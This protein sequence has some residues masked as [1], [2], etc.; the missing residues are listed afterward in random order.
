MKIEHISIIFLMFISSCGIN[1]PE[2]K[3]WGYFPLSV[4]NEWNYKIQNNPE[5]DY[6]STWRVNSIT[7]ISGKEYF[8]IIK[9][10]NLNSYKDTSYFRIDGSKLV[11]LIIT[12][13][14]QNF[15]TTFAD[16]SVGDDSSF[17]YRFFNVT[18][19]KKDKNS[20]TL[21]YDAPQ[22]VDEENSITFEKNKGITLFY[23]D[24]WGIGE[25]LF[26]YQIETQ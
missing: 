6:V 7:K 22:M 1:D 12:N 26:D 24:A 18:L 5:S 19:K 11:E 10:N 15:E 4:G 13:N 3:A 9:E 14:N 21:F 17:K 25:Y 20:I 16:F 8:E 23:S 2:E